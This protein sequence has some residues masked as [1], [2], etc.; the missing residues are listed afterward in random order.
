MQFGFEI[1]A[2]KRGKN[3]ILFLTRMR[4]FAILCLIKDKVIPIT[5]MRRVFLKQEDNDME[6]YVK[7]VMEV[8]LFVTDIVTASVPGGCENELPII[9]IPEEPN[10][11]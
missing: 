7:P 11:N 1:R 2:G 4:E 8:E 10:F 5:H 6:T 3:Y 9:S